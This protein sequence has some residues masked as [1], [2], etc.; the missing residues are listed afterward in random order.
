MCN[1]LYELFGQEE[2]QLLR[3]DMVELEDIGIHQL[4]FYNSGITFC[5]GNMEHVADEPT[6]LG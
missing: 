3:E 2:T 4:Q 6:D 5:H 1:E